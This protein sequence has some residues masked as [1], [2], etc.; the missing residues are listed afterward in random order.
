MTALWIPD[1]TTGQVVLSGEFSYPTACRLRVA[2]QAKW[3]RNESDP[4]FA[5]GDWELNL[6]AFVGSGSSR[7]TAI[8]G[9]NNY[10]AV[11]ETP[12]AGGYAVV[13]VGIEFVSY[14]AGGAGSMWCTDL[15]ISCHRLTEV[16]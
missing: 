3:S 10:T 2:F 1:L 4:V 13:P 8:M 16:A 11:L 7:L 14:S 9:F 6:R 5:Y 12:Y 15:D